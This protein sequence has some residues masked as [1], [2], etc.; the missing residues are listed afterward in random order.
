MF[1][2]SGPVVVSPKKTISFQLCLPNGDRQ[3]IKWWKIK[4]HSV[5]EIT[6]GITCRISRYLYGPV[7]DD[8]HTFEITDAETEDSATY[9][10]SFKDRASNKICVLV[11][12][13]YVFN[14]IKFLYY[15]TRQ[16][17]ST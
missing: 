11:D 17:I 9:Y 15:F 10:F 2:V 7:K 5:K 14:D 13:K 1:F 16:I 8:L 6:Y 12:G 4:D 3:N